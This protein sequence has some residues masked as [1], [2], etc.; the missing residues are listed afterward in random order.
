MNR[1]KE[2]RR[3]YKIPQ[4]QLAIDLKVS[5]PTICMWEKGDREPTNVS[6]ARIADYFG[7]SMDYL[8]GRS[9]IRNDVKPATEDDGELVSEI[10]SRIRSLPQDCLPQLL[11]YLDG[12]KAGR[13]I[14]SVTSADRDPVQP[15]GR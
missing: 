15:P 14:A 8:L 6:A 11:A 13:D 1:I 4:K 12:L 2:L 9:D 5:Q 10:I 3:K 7:V